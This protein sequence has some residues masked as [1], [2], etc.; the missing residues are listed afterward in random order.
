MSP[1]FENLF[2]EVSRDYAAMWDFKFRGTTLEIVTPHST[3]SDKFISV[4]LTER[5]NFFVI[6]DD[7]YLHLGDYV[8]NEAIKAGRCY[9]NAF[10]HYERYY[11]IQRVSDRN[12][13]VIFFTKTESRTMVTSLIHDMAS[14]IVG[15]ANAQQMTLETDQEVVT[16]QRFAKAAGSF[17]LDAFPGRQI[18]FNQ[19]LRPDDR[20]HFSAGVW[21]ESQV[22]LIQFITG[23]DSYHFDTSMAKAT[24]N[25]LAVNG[26]ALQP[27]VK[28]KI[29]LIDTSAGGYGTGGNSSYASLLSSTSSMLY[30]E[31]R[32]ELVDLVET[33]A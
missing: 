33:E 23:Y 22:S 25:F 24:M 7:G 1:N 17:L 10:S 28:K 13:K 12:G 2:H 30:W 29:S 6:T 9:N 31:E 5:D 27:A 11:A 16:K 14:F 21:R 26:S 32:R 3:I 4:F 19:E 15:V 18:K 8:E 20:I